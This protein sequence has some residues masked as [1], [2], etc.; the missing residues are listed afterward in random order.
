MDQKRLNPDSKIFI[1][2]HRG[3]VGSAICRNLEAKGYANLIT[4]SRDQLNL[5]SQHEVDQFFASEKPEFVVL[6]AAKVGGIHANRTYQA[7][8][9]YENM[10][11]AANVI[12]SAFIHDTEKLLFLGSSCIYPRLA[13][14]PLKEESL[15]TGS[16]EPTNEGYA[17]A[18]IAGLKLCENI[19]K[20]YGRR[21]ISAMPTNLFG[22]FDNYHP[23]HA[24]VIPMLLRRFH[25]AKIDDAP[26]V[27]VWGSGTPRREFLHVDDLAE[28]LFVLL[29]QYE[30]A[31]TINIGT[32]QDLTIKELAESMKNVT[33]YSGK[34]VWDTSKPDGTPRKLL[35]VSRIEKLGWKPRYTF[36]EGLRHAYE[37]AVENNAF[38][39]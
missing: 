33:G 3:L 28:G 30:E 37:W 1:A 31:Q 26:E 16:L 13:E 34:I 39:S 4:R 21:F 10:M 11:I 20:Q 17:I 38:A 32:G 12:H 6:A 27:T 25:Q 9:L 36:E 8:F 22:P 5:L 19:Q 24:H 15:L 7:E 2:G 35:D 18:K 23:E 29:D 14:Q